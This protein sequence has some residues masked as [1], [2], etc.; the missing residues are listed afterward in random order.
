M[1]NIWQLMFLRVMCGVGLGGEQPVGST[2]V[3]ESLPEDRRVKF[4]G[5]LHTGYYAGFLLAS[6]ANYFIGANYGWR[7][8]FAFG[9]LPAIFVGWIMSNV[10]E[11]HKFRR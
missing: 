6:I 10:K 3:A 7:W 11:S 4:A 9:G 5:F 1:T 8:M 2:F